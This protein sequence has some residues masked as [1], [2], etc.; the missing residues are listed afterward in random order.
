MPLAADQHDA[1]KLVTS[2]L[3]T[4]AVVHGRA[5]V[6]V[7]L[8]LSDCRVL[9]VVHDSSRTLPVR[10]P[11]FDDDK[12]SG[13]GLFLVDSF[14]ARSGWS[15]TALGKRVRA[16]FE[17]PAVPRTRASLAARRAQIARAKPPLYVRPHGL[18]LAAAI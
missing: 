9:L 4:N 16:E 13:L 8:Y 5:P 2:E 18:A 1:I 12:E 3:V 14:A 15:A 6:N 11:Y 17:V 7:G 10:R